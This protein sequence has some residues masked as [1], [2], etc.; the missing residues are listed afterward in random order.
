MIKWTITEE[1]YIGTTQNFIQTNKLAI[2]NLYNTI[3]NNNF[4]PLYP[5][6]KEKL[7]RLSD[8]SIIIYFNTTQNITTQL[9]KLIETLNIEAK[10]YFTDH[11]NKYTKP[12][13]T[14]INDFFSQKLDSESFIC[15]N[16]IVDYKF[17]TNSNLSYKIP[18]NFF[19]NKQN[20][21]PTFLYPL[22]FTEKPSEINIQL[23]SQPKDMI[24]LAGYQASGKST[25]AKYLF[26]KYGYHILSLDEYVIKKNL[27][28]MNKIEN[29]IKEHNLIV[30][31][32]FCLKQIRKKFID[33]GKKYGYYIRTI[34]LDYD[35]QLIKHNSYYRYLKEGRE[36]ANVF[37]D[38]KFDLSCNKNEGIDDIIYCENFYPDDKLY[39]QYAF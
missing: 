27:L 29:I 5:N 13:P 11:F 9:E 33:I 12:Y 17:A 26:E 32:Y 22:N 20:I 37:Y 24:I 6:I 7:K 34:I 14:L 4:E 25:I 38:A 23:N 35:Q 36:I 15:G 30:I 18:D 1:L 21:I 3:I 2:F 16:E 28:T 10:I 19:L 39:Y 31:D 8:Y